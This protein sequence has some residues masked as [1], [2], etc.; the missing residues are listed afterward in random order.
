VKKLTAHRQKY[1]EEL[2]KLIPLAQTETH[3]FDEAAAAFLGVNRTDLKCLGIVLEQGAVSAGS[4]A[5][6]VH[7]TRGS[8]TTALDRLEDQKLICRKDDPTDR[9]GVQVEATS[10]AKKAVREIWGPLAEEGAEILEGYSD[11][12]LGTLVRFFKNYC[13]LQKNQ[14]QRLR[15]RVN[16]K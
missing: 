5:D 11:R 8:M 6:R 13:A 15:K 10:E 3:D 12:E 7:L 9:R 16:K 14:S 2:R 1:L 4:L